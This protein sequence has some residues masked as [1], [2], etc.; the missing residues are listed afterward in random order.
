MQ[1]GQVFLRE[2]RFPAFERCPPNALN[3]SP[4]VPCSEN[5][6]SRSTYCHFWWIL[7]LS[8]QYEEKG[9]APEPCI[10]KWPSAPGSE[11]RRE[12]GALSYGRRRPKYLR[13]SWNCSRFRTEALFKTREKDRSMNNAFA[14]MRAVKGS[15]RPARLTA[16]PWCVRCRRRS[17]PWCGEF[18]VYG[19]GGIVHEVVPGIPRSKP[20]KLL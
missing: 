19:G 2:N 6:L 11:F 15:T 7:V 4:N 12:R 1:C 14:T 5:P 16:V 8:F 17:I 20:K 3:Y 10:I 13:V 18:N 9:N